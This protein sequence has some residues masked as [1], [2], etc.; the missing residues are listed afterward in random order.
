MDEAEAYLAEMDDIELDRQQ[1]KQVAG[2]DQ[3]EIF[4]PEQVCDHSEW[5]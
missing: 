5:W 1:L 4:D 2:G 3:C